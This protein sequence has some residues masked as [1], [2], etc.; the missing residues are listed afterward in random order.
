MVEYKPITPEDVI[1]HL[2]IDYADDM[3]FRNIKSAITAAD[4]YLK[5]SIGE[6]YPVDDPRVKQIALAVVAD[7]Y[8]ERGLHSTVSGNV[9]RL[10]DDFSWQLRLE[11]R[12]GANGENI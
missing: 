8:D 1:A 4:F 7:L 9:R 2:G 6:G 3:V 11:M 10:I 5:G 12:R